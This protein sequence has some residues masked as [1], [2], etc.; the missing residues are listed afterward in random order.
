MKQVMI[1]IWF[2][3]KKYPFVVSAFTDRMGKARP[4]HDTIEECL[5][6]IGVGPDDDYKIGA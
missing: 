1:S 2:K 6:S 4:S 5:D 3:G